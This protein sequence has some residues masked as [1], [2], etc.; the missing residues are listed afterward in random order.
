MPPLALAPSSTVVPAVWSTA[1]THQQQEEA[2]E[3]DTVMSFGGKCFHY[4]DPRALTIGAHLRKKQDDDMQNFM[5]TLE[6]DNL[7]S[8]LD[9][10]TMDN[11]DAFMTMLE[12]VVFE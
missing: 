9:D 8:G 7:Y 10:A 11:D 12:R 6:L 5:S 3:I 2:A 1:P 4:L